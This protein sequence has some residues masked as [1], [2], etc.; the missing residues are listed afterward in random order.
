MPNWRILIVDD[1]ED[2]RKIVRASLATKYEVVE[3]QDGLDALE[4]L[5]LAEPD[6][7]VLDVM[8][9]LMNG[10]ETCA[11]IRRHARFKG[12]PVLFLS[13]LNT[14]DDMKKGYGVGANLYLTKPFDPARLLRNVDV[15][16]EENP[17]VFTRKRYT[18][19]D[20]KELA[21]K[22]TH[23]LAEAHAESD[24]KLVAISDEDLQEIP[25]ATP[26]I[27][28]PPPLEVPP[29]EPEEPAP[30]APTER[31]WYE[32][33]KITRASETKAPPPS[34]VPG[35]SEP[36]PL[37]HRHQAGPP[38][39]RLLFVDDD[40]SILLMARTYLQD[41]YEF[42][43]ALDGIEAIEK[44]T[45]L[46]PDIIVLDAMMPKM[47][48]YQLCQSLRRNA[49]FAKTPILFVSTKSTQRE[50]DYALRIGGTDFLAKPFDSHQ[51]IECL[52]KIQ[53]SPDFRIQ[54]K[55][56][57]LMQLAEVENS[58]KKQLE[59]HQD[60]LHRKEESELEKFLREHQ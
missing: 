51:L 48:G 27:A 8:M 35:A 47:S 12:T 2:I 11:A 22:G 40:Q 33:R 46:Q 49:R 15:F 57:D 1:E 36:T 38:K 14:K 37:Y 53:K 4:K 19:D 18:L 45:A 52:H 42:A 41:D 39:P 6:F 56:I 28:P 55:A 5:E 44:I 16:F 60:R 50:H 34:K 59:E 9:P 7:V 29:P 23:A 3:A 20:L 13:A 25:L 24:V 26:E 32:D 58:R 54:P 30:Q 17:P 43:T 21:T 31:A 10:F